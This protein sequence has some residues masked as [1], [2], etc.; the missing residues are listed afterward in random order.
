[1]SL[2]EKTVADTIVDYEH[3]R[4]LGHDYTP[5]ND[6]LTILHPVLAE[7]QRLRAVIHGMADELEHTTPTGPM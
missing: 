6:V 2:V 7:L 5:I 1:M 3:Q 4:H